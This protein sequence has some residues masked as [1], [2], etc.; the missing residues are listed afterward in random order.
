MEELAIG[1]KESSKQFLWVLKESEHC[2]LP[3]GFVDSKEE[4]SSWKM[5]GGLRS[6]VDEKGIVGKEESQYCIREVMEGKRREE[7]KR[8]ANKWREAAKAAIVE[9]GSSIKNIDKF[10][11]HLLSG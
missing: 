8:N 7:F 5:F 11:G 4:I 1:L 9:S 10:A 6:K 2:K 3:D